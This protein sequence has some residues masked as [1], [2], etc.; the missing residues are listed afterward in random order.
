MLLNDFPKNRM[1]GGSCAIIQASIRSTLI[2]GFFSFIYGVWTPV[3]PALAA[4]SEPPGGSVEC[5]GNVPSA[6]F[7][8][9]PVNNLTIS[10]LTGNIA[11]VSLTGAGAYS[12]AVFEIKGCS[13]PGQCTFGFDE[14]SQTNYCSPN[15]NAPTGT[16][17]INIPVEGGT[18]D[19]AG[20]NLNVSVD[21][22]SYLVTPGGVIA[23]SSGLQGQKGRDAGFDRDGEDGKP[24]SDGGN[25][26]VVLQ[27]GLKTSSGQ[28]TLNATS[29]GGSG[30]TGGN[31]GPLDG[32]KPGAGGFGGD[33]GLA[34]ALVGS[35]SKIEVVGT[36]RVGAGSFS[37]G[38]SSGQGGSDSGVVANPGGSNK[39][40]AGGPSQVFL[41]GDA[42]ITTNGAN[43][44]GVQARSQ[45]GGGA[46]A[47]DGYGLFW[48]SPATGGTGGN[49]GIVQVGIGANAK[50]AIG[51]E[52][53][54]TAGLI[55]TYGNSASGIFAQSIGGLG[56]AG[57][58][59]LGLVIMGDTGGAGGD[60]GDVT[61]V[62][63][64]KITT[65]GSG[66]H[67]IYAQSV[68]GGGG[69][70]GN[71][72][73]AI[74]IGGAGG[75]SAKAG[76]V[77]VANFADI[78]A[79][80]DKAK[81]IYA[82]SVGGGGGEGSTTGGI[83]SFGG[84]GGSAS[85]ADGQS[86][87]VTNAGNIS[88]GNRANK[89]SE[90]TGI[91][92]QSVGG[93]GGS[94]GSAISLTAGVLNVIP[95]IAFGGAGS[96]GGNGGDVSVLTNTGDLNTA[97]I[98]EIQTVGDNS[99][100]ILAQS[101][102]GGGG[103]GGF[104]ITTA[105]S[106]SGIATSLGFAGSGADAGS[107]G[108]VLVQAAGKLTTDGN[109]SSG[110]YAQ[111]VGSG[112][113]KG[114][115]A[116]S[117][118]VGGAVGSFSIA[119]G[120]SGGIGGNA[121]KVT[122]NSATSINVKGNQTN[123]IF[124]QSEGGGGGD[125]GFIVNTTQSILQT[126]GI[127]MGGKT[128]SG[129]TSDQVSINNKGG[130]T[131]EGE[132][133]DAIY[134]QS[135]GGGG[136]KAGF[137]VSNSLAP[138]GVTL[139][140]G[141]D[142]GSGGKSGD[143]FVNSIGN[144]TTNGKQSSGILAQ[145]I[146]GGGGDVAFTF[147]TPAFFDVGELGVSTIGRAILGGANGG[148][149]NTGGNVRVD[150]NGDIT[151]N[152]NQSRGI[153]AQSIGG[154]GG[155]AATDV[156]ITLV[157]AAKGIMGLFS[158]GNVGAS[159]GDGAAAKTVKLDYEGSIHTSGAA[160][161]GVVAQSIGG[162]GGQGGNVLAV[163]VTATPA[164]L[165]GGTLSAV[166]GTGGT[167]NTSSTVDV[168]LKSGL[169]GYTVTTKGDNSDGILAQSIGGGG[170]SGGNVFIGSL[171]VKGS[172][173]IQ[174]VGGN[175]GNGGD[176]T[177]SLSNPAVRVINQGNIR[178]AGSES[179][180]I[181]AQ[182]IGGGGGKG[183]FA[184]TTALS[185]SEKATTFESVGGNGGAS[186]K[187]ATVNVKSNA[188]D[189]SGSFILTQ[190]PLAS[191]IVAQS[192]GGGGGSGGIA[193]GTNVAAASATSTGAVD[194]VI[195]VGGDGGSGN[196]AGNVD[197]V[198]GGKII[199][200]AQ[201]K[202]DGSLVAS[203]NGGGSVGILAQSIGGG[204]GDG[205][206]SGGIQFSASKASAVNV[207]GGKGGQGSDGGSVA[208]TTNLGSEIIT[209]DNK[210]SAIEAQSIGG[211]GGDGGF[212]VA[213]NISNS[214]ATNIKNTVGATGG[215]AGAGG[216]SNNVS[217]TNNANLLTAGLESK[218]ILAQSIGGGGGVGGFAFAGNFTLKNG[219]AT[220]NTVGGDGGGGQGAGS[221]KVINSGKI[222]TQQDEASAILAQSIGGGGGV[223]GIA[224]AITIT[225]GG[226]I[227]NNVGGTGKASGGDASNGG[228][229]FVTNNA[230]IKT[231]GIKSYGIL[232]ESIG[233]GGGDGG[234]VVGLSVNAGRDAPSTVES[235][236]NLVGSNGGSGGNGARVEVTNNAGGKISTKGDFAYG[237]YANSI[238]G[239]GGHGSF[240][241]GGGV[242]LS[243]DVNMDLG[244]GSGAKGGIGGSVAISN[245]NNSISTSG[246]SASAIVAQSIGGGG[247][248]AGISSGLALNVGGSGK[249]SQTVGGNGGSGGAAGSVT[250]TSNFVDGSTALLLTEGIKSAG[251]LAQSIGGGGGDGGIF[252]GGA[253]NMAGSS[254]VTNTVGG[255]GASGNT[256]G[257]VIVN[258]G[259]AIYTG[260]S[261]GPDGKL[262]KSTS[263]GTGSTGILAQSIG[264]GGGAGLVS[265]GLTLGLDGGGSAV[266]AI[267]GKGGFASDGGA[268]NVTTIADG[269]IVTFGDK[270]AGILAQSIG[271]GGG[272]G[273]FVVSSSSN[274]KAK[275]IANTLGGSLDGGSAGN[276]GKG[277][278]A[279]VNNAANIQ[280]AG[281]AS[282]G[283]IAQSVGGGGG[284]GGFAFAADFIVSKKDGVTSSAVG[285]A[286][287]NGGDANAAKVTNAGII[288]VAGDGAIGLAAQ[289]IGG[290]GGAGGFAGR[291]IFSDAGTIT[292]N[293]G[294]A[295]KKV[296]SGGEGS[297]GA[298]VDVNNNGNIKTGGLK[299]TALLAQSI[300]GGGGDGG[301]AIA[302]NAT[303]E[304][305][306]AKILITSVGGA[307]GYGGSG[308]I[309]T[310]TNGSLGSIETLADMSNALV[311]QSI[312][313]GGG[314]GGFAI[315]GNLTLETDSKLQVGGGAGDGGGDAGAVTVINQG[316]ITT[317]GAKSIAIT[318]QSI[319]G[320][321]GSGGFS[322]GL[323]IT[324]AGKID[325][326]I[327]SETTA[328][329]NGG[330]ASSVKVINS[331]AGT[332]T[333]DGVKSI[334]ILA[335]AIA[336]GGGEGGFAISG[337][338]ALGAGITEKVGGN[339]GNAG[340]GGSINAQTTVSV[341]NEGT[342]TTNGAQSTGIMAQSVGG[343]GGNG[344]IVI[345]G[346]GSTASGGAISTDLGGS[347]GAGGAG[348]AV[349][350][351]NK[352]TINLNGAVSMGILA[353]SIGGGGGSS[354]FSG[355]LNLNGNTF[356]VAVGQAKGGGGGAGGSVNVSNTGSINTKDDNSIPIL[357][358][359]I[360][361]GGG[362]SAWSLTAQA[363]KFSGFKITIGTSAGSITA[364]NGTVNVTTAEGS[365]FTA[366]ALAYGSLTQS[367]GGGGGN[368]AFA[369][370]GD[371][372]VD[373]AA[374]SSGVTLALGAKTA[375]EV[376]NGNADTVTV[377]NGN[378]IV[379]TGAGGTALITQSI[380]AGGGVAGVAGN[381]N[382]VNGAPIAV[383]LGS[384][385]STG[386]NG[387]L[388]GVNYK[389]VLISTL[390]NAAAGMIS[391]SIGG[392]GGIVINALG[393]VTG[394]P[395]KTS[396]TFGSKDLASQAQSNGG[397][398]QLTSS[399]DVAT[400]GVFSPGV[401]AQT[402]GGGGGFGALVANTGLTGQNLA[403][404]L[405]A[406]NGTANQTSASA[407]PG[408][409][410]SF[411]IKEGAIITAGDLSGGAT[412]QAIGGGG[413][414]FGFS[415]KAALTNNVVDLTLGAR[416]SG[417]GKITGNGAP[418]VLTNQ[419]SI[420]TAGEGAYGLLA[421][422]IGGGGGVV[423]MKGIDATSGAASSRISI[424]GASG[425]SGNG[426]D[427]NV[428]SGGAITTTGTNA[429][430]I[431]AQSIGGGG[432][433]FL[434]FNSNG[435]PVEP[436]VVKEAG[437][438]GSGGKVTVN[439]NAPIQV[440]GAGAIGVLAQ[441]IGGGGG[442][443]AGKEATAPTFAGSAGGEG[444]SGEVILNVN[445]KITA[446]G[447]GANGVY[448]QS[449][450]KNG[451]ETVTDSSNDRKVK[452]NVASG[453]EL[454]GDGPD[455]ELL[456][457][458][459]V[460]LNDA[461]HTGVGVEVRDAKSFDLVNYGTVN[462]V[463]GPRGIAVFSTAGQ[464]TYINFGRIIGSIASFGDSDIFI[465]KPFHSAENPIPHAGV[466]DAGSIV[467]LG[468][469]G[470]FT[471][472]GAFIIGGF[473]DGLN[474]NLTGN[475]TQTGNGACG[476]Y[477][478]PTTSCG[479]LAADVNV[480][481]GPSGQL[482]ISGT[483]GVSGAIVVNPISGG[484]A[485]PGS[486]TT[487]VLRAAGGLTTNNLQL[488][489][490]TSAVASYG[491]TTN[492]NEIGV[493]YT[494]NFAPVGL[495]FNQRAPA[496]AVNAIQASGAFPAFAPVANALFV[497]PN[498]L[499]LGAAYNSLSGEGVTATQQTTF[500]ANDFLHSSANRQMNF[501][502]YDQE[503]NGGNS[504]TLYDD[505]ADIAPDR[506]W[507][508]TA[509]Y[510]TRAPRFAERTWK[511][512]MIGSGGA[513]AYPGQAST[514][515][516]N[517]SSG[518]YGFAGGVDRQITPNFLVGAAGGY[519]TYGFGVQQR[520]TYGNVYGGHVAGYA[521]L[522]GG[523][524]YATG[525]LS[526][527]FFDNYA[528]RT[529]SIAGSPTTTLF[530]EN[531]YTPGVY[532]NLNGKFGSR[533]ISGMGEAGYRA[534]VGALDVTP[535]AAL[536][537]SS[538][539]SDGFNEY[540]GFSQSIVALNYQG[541]TI[542]S[543][544]SY[545]G[546]QFNHNFELSNGMPLWGWVRSAWRHE[547]DQLRTV[548][549]AF[550]AAPGM[551]FTTLGAPG[552]RDMA[553]VSSGVK[554]GLTPNLALFAGFDGNFA[555][556]AYAVAGTGGVQMRW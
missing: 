22:G 152:G 124:A 276:G 423:L 151:T 475:Y 304:S 146:G 95:A 450:T 246:V 100:A 458:R 362:N 551:N 413:G 332:I 334:G 92:A 122:V 342:I 58:F 379:T 291:M 415:S 388:T 312:G 90:S 554:L 83:I 417:A 117:T 393:A 298:A 213:A 526:G 200:G 54:K 78:S 133:S 418:V 372:T 520:Q 549:T 168:S 354:G 462:V 506:K 544:P 60:G 153:I 251:I 539:R 108:D 219:N 186:G 259:G 425:V 472:E 247:G 322:G 535:F 384:E 288:Q 105:V 326:Q 408:T 484:S 193:I 278:S 128:G 437:G 337:N 56:G 171:N 470:Q 1:L 541:R 281:I 13:V 313:G 468:V 136:G 536:Q 421:Q 407:D 477:G 159:G 182:S 181:V 147:T 284:E 453:I 349:T 234:I 286:G 204:G 64:D 99:P 41:Y 367:I 436:T 328:G 335:Q 238:G 166:G 516:A 8:S 491:L 339:G 270:A 380:G 524:F 197:V 538:L 225:N 47:S 185:L 352:G 62:N 287:G 285:G 461:L 305:S 156:E 190:G 307:G 319:G 365:I 61:V 351:D 131:T 203:G 115:F 30:G 451:N 82:Q 344:G 176:S 518:G 143:V 290:G 137:I 399:G 162:G 385:G 230:E 84:K 172:T 231:K 444:E 465:N 209:F 500:M 269:K 107:A 314:N 188:I 9:P 402:I 244:A 34:R 280:T 515:S 116:V 38:G 495:T 242:N 189:N 65:L 275:N 297:N 121:G 514:G 183:G 164:E 167:G 265:A 31:S 149:G 150:G 148:T 510:D 420:L 267:G 348:G 550:M 196:S 411:T 364:S 476:S 138:F 240:I 135:L 488:Q 127:S 245:V 250:V 20:P 163:A 113:G 504:L 512:W 144:L 347:G 540:N 299:S 212:V 18:A 511:T 52:E 48:S 206:F 169:D 309:V 215:D 235:L 481:G 35:G 498:V 63:A 258:A 266:N 479:Y 378:K 363:G 457:L 331:A 118:A 211:G 333:T 381:L 529:V 553:W 463:N 433:L 252:A 283:L 93:G 177:D 130:I 532:D 86:V 180:G 394:Q 111:S 145:S 543:L 98:F 478:A 101:L 419:S 404:S 249:V 556:S 414:M 4:C 508:A 493:N 507:R 409:T 3:S 221:V 301:F 534:K 207:T 471:N 110:I 422:S 346:S 218:G 226:K 91:Y 214:D 416:V 382:I 525:V 229:V 223:G 88:T 546:M 97:Q 368:F 501:W 75:G 358:Q 496:F 43:A 359:K 376:F 294:A 454:I 112:G 542:S 33:G 51:L 37:D 355:G 45:G 191:A 329:A 405:G 132:Q 522:K 360:D 485:K 400:V 338:A 28:Y 366:G 40:G 24:G 426:A 217:I 255:N 490:P 157:G 5:S 296:N 236:S 273:G 315:G 455:P 282:H 263:G 73:G 46:K 178:T 373:K 361:G 125:T 548:T 398:A 310:V 25:V 106:V 277:L 198:A 68:G 325:S 443:V 119:Q 202:D 469:T 39:A 59:N 187:G 16:K 66:A 396:F 268:V 391:Q 316:A 356:S 57:D 428:T 370:R 103:V 289:S 165:P 503:D 53:V 12:K 401:V 80:G 300:G 318:A 474:T 489:A 175:G 320:G 442:F 435:A 195:T 201:T 257:T 464:D 392:G 499:A 239:G 126:I 264:G 345:N 50:G 340:S 336:G 94:G 243:G 71:A 531:V 199:T 174:A 85:N 81:G 466:F 274:N 44:Y 134:A 528:H 205:G 70:A 445:A 432:G 527:D 76:A 89:T 224:G 36:N 483:A 387:A 14:Q 447:Q 369:S 248:S 395:V 439:V 55:T 87:T 158:G 494:V 502:L 323:N 222:T 480:G 429:Y 49:G 460:G 397:G 237:I 216:A 123:G 69:K 241:F 173:N 155:K 509:P 227:T 302:A 555:P 141:G 120:G 74:A 473:Y 403:L 15:A 452:I 497:Q 321:G 410:S 161:D 430:G 424:G 72:G 96:V 184:I 343:G 330:T 26:A 440:L 431:V 23:S 308:Q 513:L 371:I 350:V 104:T 279:T 303:R 42:S 547:F 170:G 456:K 533:S 160:S 19:T 375:G 194:E 254:Q 545:V 262:I 406:T 486:G 505:R 114:G 102:G 220:T 27:G 179:A 261:I 341:I 77:G 383:S 317:R 256:A 210:S 292:N 487:T 519:G 142:G 140:L 11:S 492:A 139:S 537:F 530:D 79:S 228:D 233:G 32:S 552:V 374:D 427:V 21:T 521:A 446:V 232:A 448:V 459:S 192:I 253:V 272:D 293:V 467:D 260:A 109:S 377:S 523:P 412:V 357:A 449:A 17:C 2:I 306:S 517:M 327:G 154:G 67:G 10:N 129:G 7:V 295:G 441:S 438:N 271:G 434:G 29:L 390:G 353:Q 386:G 6:T 208:V 389:G 324:K 482:N 311:A